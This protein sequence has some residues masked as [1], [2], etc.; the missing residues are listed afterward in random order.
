[1][2]IRLTHIVLVNQSQ[3]SARNFDRDNFTIC[4]PGI[5]NEFCSETVIEIARYVYNTI[6]CFVNDNKSSHGLIFSLQTFLANAQVIFF[7]CWIFCQLATHWYF[8]N[9]DV[10]KL[11]TLNYIYSMWKAQIK[12]RPSYDWSSHPHLSTKVPFVRF[13]PA[14]WMLPGYKDQNKDSHIS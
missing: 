13:D 9:K 1:M 11:Q 6:E 14:D 3:N 8:K 4:S 7:A 5:T 2:H 10:D 12:M